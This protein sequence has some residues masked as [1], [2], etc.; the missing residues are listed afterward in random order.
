MKYAGIL[1]P[2]KMSPEAR[3]GYLSWKAQRSKCRN[4]NNKDYKYYGGKGVQIQYSSRDFV[5]W[6]LTNLAKRKS[7]DTPT[8]GRIDHNGH[9][10]FENIEMQERVENST[11]RMNRLGPYRVDIEVAVYKNG[12]F[13]ARFSSYNEAAEFCKIHSATVSKL[14]NRKYISGGKLKTETSEGYSFKALNGTTTP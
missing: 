4:K 10:C 5:S 11:E 14:A 9:Y 7:W 13:L 6:W 3:Q 8:V 2:S 12:K 1:D